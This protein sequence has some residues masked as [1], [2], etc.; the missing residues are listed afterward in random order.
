MQPYVLTEKGPDFMIDRG[1]FDTLTGRWYNHRVVIRDG[2]RKDKPFFVRLYNPNEISNLIQ[3]VG[4]Q[5]DKI[6]GGFDS[7]PL[8]NDSQRM[9]IIAQKPL[10]G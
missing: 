7:Q 4:L 10:S 2:I 8:T 3:Q 5:V 1:S 6:F 9:V